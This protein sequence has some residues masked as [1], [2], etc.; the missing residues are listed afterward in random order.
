MCF[1]AMFPKRLE[2]LKWLKY[3]LSSERNKPPNTAER[4]GK[5]AAA[6]S[7]GWGW[8]G[9][10]SLA[11]SPHSSWFGVVFSVPVHTGANGTWEELGWPPAFWHGME[12]PNCHTK[13]KVSLKGYLNAHPWSWVV[14][15]KFTDRK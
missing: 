5:R 3:P 6:S 10:S 8:G 11:P 13:Y 1:S 12:R 15:P 4:D 7:P 2:A 9:S 14:F